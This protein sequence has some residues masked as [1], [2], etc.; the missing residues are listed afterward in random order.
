MSHIRDSSQTLLKKIADNTKTMNL[1]VDSLEVNTDG[2]EGLLTTANNATLRD[3][4]NTGSIGDGSSNATSVSLGYDRSNGQGRA[5]LVDA[6]GNQSVN[7]VSGGDISTKLDNFSGAVN[8]THTGIGDGSTQ[9]R[10]IALGHDR[11]NGKAV[12]F[13][14]DADGH[15][16]IDVVGGGF[17]ST[18]LATSALQTTG[19]TSLSTIAGDTTSIDGKI[20]A[21]NTGAVVVSSSALPTGAATSANQTTANTHLSEIEGAVETIEGCVGSNKVNVN[22]SSGNITG[23]ATSALQGAGLP[24]ALS[25]DNLKV[26]IQEGNISGFATSALQGAGLPSALSSDNLKVSIQEGN[27][28]G[29]ATSSNQTTA[30]THL[31]EIE[32][33]VETI[34]GCVGSNKVNVNISSGNITGFATSALQGAGLPSALSSN[35]LRVSIQEGNITG[36]ATATLQGA[37]LPSALSSDNL[38]VSIQEGNITGFATASNQSTTNT[39]L[40]TIETDIEATNTLLTTIDNV[41]DDA[42]THLGS[43][44]TNI[45]SVKTAVEL[46]DNAVDSNALNVNMNIAGNDVDSNSGN[47]SANTP[48]VVIATDD[49][50]VAKITSAH[51]LTTTQLHNGTSISG[52]GG[53][54]THSTVFTLTHNPRSITIFA[55]D[56]S[57]AGS[58]TGDNISI[59]PMVSMDNS[60][61]FDLR[62]ALGVGGG[63]INQLTVSSL[64]RESIVVIEN[65]RFK[66][67][68]VK[69]TNNAGGA[70]NFDSFVCF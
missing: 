56:S 14:V 68:K 3:I 12:S 58:I 38:K 23:F 21:C 65:C 35:N 39:K 45:A 18:G 17:S 40:G 5:I 54:D 4:N 48:R 41:L 62:T 61:F 69:I 6:S 64:L 26:S 19:N 46:L 25:S 29:F 1:N 44:D 67:L 7:V 57:G 43:I 2:L 10:T 55:A 30:N 33:A 60:T 28:T 47:K 63:S 49:I 37:G 66:F 9:L 15:Q 32:G 13:L 50:N 22:I 42:E 53:S 52:S 51:E 31:S 16:Q 24:S 59:S 70:I 36:F 34:E 11:S 27:I 20:T 8:N